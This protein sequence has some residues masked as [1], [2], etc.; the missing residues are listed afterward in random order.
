MKNKTKLLTLILSLLLVFGAFG[1]S[2]CGGDSSVVINPPAP[3]YSV[4][5]VT[6]NYNG[7]K[8]D[9]TLSADLSSESLSLSAVVRK[10]DQADGAVSY[11][12][13]NPLV[14]TIAADGTVTLL[15]EGETVITASAGGKTH[16]IVLKVTDSFAAN[17]TSYTITVNGGTATQTK[18]SEG[19]YVTLSAI[20][21]E[22]KSFVKWEYETETPVDLWI[23][24]NKFKMPACA[25]DITAVY[26]DKLYTL[27]VVGATV[28]D[29]GN[30]QVQEG[31]DGG[32]Y[33]SG[34]LVQHDITTY[35]YAYGTEISVEAIKAPAGK[36]F[37]GW[38]YAVVDNR[39][40]EMGVDEYS[41]TMPGETLTVWAIFS[42]FSNK[43]LTANVIDYNAQ[44]ISNG[45]NDPDLEG[46]NGCTLSIP[47]STMRSSDNPEN[48]RG[49]NINTIVNGSHTVKAIFK[50]H[51]ASLDVT[52]ELF[53]QY[54]GNEATT[55]SVTIPANSVK[56]VYF[57]A[58]LGLD[59]PWWG[60][61]VREDVG[62]SSSDIIQLDMVVGSAPTY[63]N[64]D[65]LLSV[66]GSAKLVELKGL[67]GSTNAGSIYSK[68]DWARSV[69]CFN[70]LGLSVF[71]NYGSEFNK[72]SGL[73]ACVAEIANLP[74]YDSND[75]YTTVYAKVINN[76][77]TGDFVGTYKLAVGYD[78]DPR[79]DRDETVL[80]EVKLE[81][82]GDVVLVAIKVPRYSNN[83][84]LYFSLVKETVDSSGSLYPHNL[85]IM[86]TY[87]NVI[88]Y[89]G[90]V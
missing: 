7:K 9:G 58:P 26:E 78:S 87:N 41:F 17:P 40:G 48:I 43:I 38:D 63:P 24:G 39:V 51:H 35:E 34:N 47:G 70:S 10:D 44:T 32:N 23:S 14:A 21:P 74:A 50:N 12:S 37:V 53:V 64:G 89:E 25:I 66:S 11:V 15:S 33:E 1:F 90:E 49:S 56:D 86:L 55:G 52:V 2:G 16:A 20:V 83:D 3:E 72:V 65:P 54:Y 57:S 31:V 61:A 73:A 69:N 6:I 8:V 28:V 19:E 68:L 75:P 29:D 18:A 79:T 5:S 80:K 85:S 77:N 84:K 88:G 27:N 42:D 81:K 62:G 71:T 76:V 30:D 13:G 60:F 46:M 67:D 82:V 36:I 22:Y 59:A 45:G 4:H